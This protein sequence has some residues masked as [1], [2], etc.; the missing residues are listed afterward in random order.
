MGF[1]SWNCKGCNYSIKSE[2]GLPKDL[3]Y[4]KEAV[5]LTPNGSVVIGEYDGYGRINDKGCET[6][7]D[8]ESGEAE[9]WHR[10][11]WEKAGKPS[12]EGPSTDAED[13]GYFYDRNI[14]GVA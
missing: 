7:I 1:F 13:Q 9:L 12:Y 4:M 14:S 5:Y 10:K 8:W 3:S 6:E 11:C 2:Y